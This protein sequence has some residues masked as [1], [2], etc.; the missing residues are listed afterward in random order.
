MNFI[1]H[2]ATLNIYDWCCKN[3]LLIHP[4]KSEAILISRRKFTGPLQALC[5]N[6]QHV[7]YVTQTKC[8]GFTIDSKLNWTSHADNVSRALSSKVKSIKRIGY[9]CPAVKEKLYFT[10]LLPSAL[11]GI[12]VWGSSSKSNIGMLEKIHIRAAKIIYNS[13]GKSKV[14]S[15]NNWKN[16]QFMY[17]KRLISLTH[18][19]YYGDCPVAMENLIK[20][21]PVIRATKNQFALVLNKPKT[22]FGRTA[23]IHRAALLWNAIPDSVKEIK[24]HQ[25][26]KNALKKNNSL[27]DNMDFNSSSIVTNKNKNEFVYF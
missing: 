4:G 11:Y 9:L 24:N 23:F 21:K 25:G 27:I 15:I 18:K 19:I 3:H 16:I 6:G 17:K 8:L 20:K 7:K 2:V 5:L 14:M 13:F 22:E 1:K 10:A 26:F 12:S